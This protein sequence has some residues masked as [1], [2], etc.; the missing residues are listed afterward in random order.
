MNERYR[1]CQR[2]VARTW[3]LLRQRETRGETARYLLTQGAA[4]GWSLG[5]QAMHEA[6]NPTASPASSRRHDTR[7]GRAGRASAS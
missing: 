6:M 3:W 1:W 2:R 4:Y 7:A 5:H